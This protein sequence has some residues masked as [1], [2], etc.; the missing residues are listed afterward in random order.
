MLAPPHRPWQ[1]AVVALAV[2]GTVTVA[3]WVND[4]GVALPAAGRWF[5][6]AATLACAAWA[7][8]AELRAAAVELQWD[9]Q[10]WWWLG[11]G[12][13]DPQP[14][15]PQV[16]ADFGRWILL[17]CGL[18]RSHGGRRWLALQLRDGETPSWHALRCALYASR[19]PR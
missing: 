18:S 5:I 13:A 7:V 9:G 17:R 15:H 10:A 4:P 19:S 2:V 11:P 3:V 8:H 12:D 16:V 14:C 1:A 6:W